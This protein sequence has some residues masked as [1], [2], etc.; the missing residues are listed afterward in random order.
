MLSDRRVDSAGQLHDPP[1]TAIVGEAFRPGFRE[2]KAIIDGLDAIALPLSHFAFMASDQLRSLVTAVAKESP[3]Y[4][5]DVRRFRRDRL[6]LIRDRLASTRTEC[7]YDRDW[8]Y[9]HFE[10]VNELA[11]LFEEVAAALAGKG[12]VQLARDRRWPER[13]GRIHAALHETLRAE[14][15]LRLS[16]LAPS[17]V[18]WAHREFPMFGTLVS[19]AGPHVG[20]QQFVD[21]ITVFGSKQ[22]PKRLF[23][24]GTDGHKYS[25]LLKGN[26]DLCMDQFQMGVL[27]FM[28]HMLRTKI[29]TYSIIPFTTNLGIIQWVPHTT[30][31]Q[32]LIL[33]CPTRCEPVNQFMTWFLPTKDSEPHLLH[34]LRPLQRLEAF[35]TV[36]ENTESDTV[37][38]REMMWRSSPNSATWLKYQ[39]NY[40]TSAGVSSIAGYLIGLG[41]R[42]LDN[43]LLEQQTGLVVHID[44]GFAL[45]GAVKRAE[46]PETVPFRLTRLMIAAMGPSGYRGVFRQACIDTIASVR[47]NEEAYLIIFEIFAHAPIRSTSPLNPLLR[48]PSENDRDTAKSQEDLSAI[49]KKVKGWEL[50]APSTVEEQVDRL[51]QMAT[52]PNN[53]CLLWPHWN[54]F[55]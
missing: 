16:A 10:R 26:E 51:I 3:N 12:Y 34:C 38:L 27:K 4:A 13:A 17:L 29:P 49:E 7:Q 25:F 24:L 54:P 21:D 22:R 23:V 39:K 33:S 6:Q 5:N 44:F 43:L 8:R 50:G 42:H 41:D 36:L 52:D 11:A 19:G 45:D 37:I 35:E 40:A 1:I 31:F 2:A 14:K 48:Q 46:F 32:Q 20:I 47:Q 18:G 55:W 30:T 9:S 15:R 28:S 53:L